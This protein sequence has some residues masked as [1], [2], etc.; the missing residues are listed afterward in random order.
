MRYKIKDGIRQS[1]FLKYG[2]KIRFGKFLE[3][4]YTPSGSVRAYD[5]CDRHL[6]FTINNKSDK[7]YQVVRDFVTLFNDGLIEEDEDETI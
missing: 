1:D 6:C 2:F 4:E 5:T 7:K 3:K